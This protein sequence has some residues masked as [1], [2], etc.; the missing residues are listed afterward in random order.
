MVP[1]FVKVRPYVAE[2]LGLSDVRFKTTDGNVLL[3]QADFL[4]FGPLS[5]LRRYVAAVGGVILRDEEAAAE[6]HDKNRIPVALP[7]PSDPD[8]AI[9]EPEPEPEETITE[10]PDSQGS[11]E[12]TESE[13][14]PEPAPAAEE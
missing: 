7:E 11:T 6:E 14:E 12:S 8:W 5:R 13:P 3:C 4:P 9:P 10:Q 2:R 1:L